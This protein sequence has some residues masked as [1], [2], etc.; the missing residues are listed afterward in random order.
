[1]RDVGLEIR[2]EESFHINDVGVLIWRTW[3]NCRGSILRRKGSGS[4]WLY[5]VWRLYDWVPGRRINTFDKNYLYLAEQAGAEMIPE[6]EVVDVRP[7][8][9]GYE[10]WTRKT[11]GFSNDDQIFHAD[12]VV[13]CGGVLGTVK[14][15]LEC[16]QN[17]SLPGI[18]D[19]LGCFVRTNSEAILV[20]ETRDR[21]TNWNDH[22]AITSGIYPDNDT[23]IEMV[24]FNE[25]SD[26]LLALGTLLTDDGA[27]IPCWVRF[28][29]NVLH[30]PLQF[31]RFLWFPGQSTRNASL[32]AM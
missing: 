26:V 9:E 1:M 5:L 14:L 6:T 16:K 11:K 13:F 15:L 32:L 29:G 3:G 23:H 19:Q 25:G 12:R 8:G 7:N 28:L 21:V 20:V 24:R 2:G 30:H 17:G 10:I 18:S 27:H 4:D 22:I 31:L